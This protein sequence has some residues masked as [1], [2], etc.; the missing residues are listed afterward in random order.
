M[1][2]TE[3]ASSRLFGPDIAPWYRR[4]LA[5]DPSVL[6]VKAMQASK[7]IPRPNAASGA[8]GRA[9]EPKPLA[10]VVCW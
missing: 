7:D 2:K 3:V 8:G 6:L 9:N 10:T 4:H 5:V 1:A